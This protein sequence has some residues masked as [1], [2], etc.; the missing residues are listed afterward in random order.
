MNTE[1]FY[2]Y[3]IKKSYNTL[4]SVLDWDI[5]K[6]TSIESRH[7]KKISAK[8]IL[9]EEHLLFAWHVFNTW[10]TNAMSHGAYLS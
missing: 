3:I 10:D 2:I 7:L 5:V 1:L 4:D 8:L 6:L 9:M